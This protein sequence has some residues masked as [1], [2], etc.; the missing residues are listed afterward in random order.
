MLTLANF[1]QRFDVL[2]LKLTSQNQPPESVTLP[3]R[4]VDWTKLRFPLKH[5]CA[6]STML[7]HVTDTGGL[8]V[9]GRVFSFGQRGK[10]FLATFDLSS[11]LVA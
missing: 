5:P 6:T 9:F 7:H 3:L 4:A 8:N 2:L 1:G 11:F 10:M